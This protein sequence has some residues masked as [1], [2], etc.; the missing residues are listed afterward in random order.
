MPHGQAAEREADCM[1]AAEPENGK[2]RRAGLAWIRLPA[3]YTKS[4]E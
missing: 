2:E 1:T 3:E 4:D